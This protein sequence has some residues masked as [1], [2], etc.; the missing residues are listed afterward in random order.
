MNAAAKS[1][2]FCGYEGPYTRSEHI[3]PESL[4]N[5]D[6]ILTNEVCDQCNQYFGKEIEAFVLEKTPLAFWRT[7]L[8]IATKKGNLPHVDLTQPSRQKGRIPSMHPIHDDKVA[9]T[10]H[11]D[12][13]VSVDIDDDIIIKEV[14]DDRRKS[15][16]FVFSP[17]VLMMMGRFLCKVGLELLCYSNP[18]L[19]RSEEYKRARQYARCGDFEGL[20]PFFHVELNS[21][22]DLIE[23]STDDNGVTE[24]VFCYDFQL[25]SILNQYTVL[26]LTVGTD[27]W[28][29]SLNNPYPTTAIRAVVNARKLNLIWYSSRHAMRRKRPSR[30]FVQFC[31]DWGLPQDI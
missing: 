30:A 1:C 19:A 7:F 16:R 5:D 4:G 29:V 13:S 23:R 14:L 2:L 6:L 21:L 18:P 8:G 25:C 26:A 10:Y 15:F 31:M 24:T 9:F 3:I 20:W 22:K 27:S 12:R 11:K 17:L 28:I